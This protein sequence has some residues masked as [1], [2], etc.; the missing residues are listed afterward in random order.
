MDT[1]QT[2]GNSGGVQYNYGDQGSSGSSQSTGGGKPSGKYKSSVTFDTKI[3]IPENNLSFDQ[4]Y[5][6]QLIAGSIALRIDEKE[7][8]ILSIPKLSQRQVDEL[9]K[10]FEEEKDEFDKLAEKYPD[11]IKQL[12]DKAKTEWKLFETKD[13]QKMEQEENKNKVDDIK[14]LLLNKTQEPK[15]NNQ[16]ELPKAA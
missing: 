8:I 16:D 14:N 12:R 13:D 2:Q 3:K 5:F 7:K 15:T 11:Q 1:N 10:I 6:L 4:N 9:M